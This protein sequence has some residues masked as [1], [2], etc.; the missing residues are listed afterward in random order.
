[1]V[2]RS[3]LDIRVDSAKTPQ[4]CGNLSRSVNGEETRKSLPFF[5]RRYWKS[6]WWMGNLDTMN[7]CLMGGVPITESNLPSGARR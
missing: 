7:D 3:V 2:S 1:M 4:H 5:L 6:I